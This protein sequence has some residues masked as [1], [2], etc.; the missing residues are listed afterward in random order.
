MKKIGIILFVLVM[1]LVSC[2]KDDDEKA[3]KPIPDTVTDIDGNLYHTTTIGTQ[4]WMV[5]NL[6]TTKY[7]NG[8]PIPNVNGE[9]WDNLTAGAYCIYNNNENNRSTY[10]LLYNWYV[11]NDSR[12]ICPVG[13]HIPTLEEW[14]T[15]AYTGLEL[16]ESG[17]THW[18]NPNNCYANNS[19]FKA[20]PGGGCGF[21]GAFNGITEYGYWWTTSEDGTENG[22]MTIM[23]YQNPGSSGSVNFD[24]WIGASIRCIKDEYE[25]K[26]K[27]KN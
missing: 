14:E 16:K 15:L 4:V 23:N 1:T 21:D 10:G 12:N 6:K 13:W 2:S 11:A 22:W 5:E 3:I 18:M 8:N 25:T 9:Q 24:K 26:S 17:T 27:L 19:G 7:R 20:L